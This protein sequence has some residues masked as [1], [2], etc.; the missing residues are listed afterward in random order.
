M[1]EYDL[2]F[3]ALMIREGIDYDDPYDTAHTGR[4]DGLFT[5]YG[6]TPA[7]QL[8]PGGDASKREEYV[9]VPGFGIDCAKQYYLWEHWQPLEKLL[10]GDVHTAVIEC[11]FDVSVHSGAGTAGRY[12]RQYG[13]QLPRFDD[14]PAALKWWDGFWYRRLKRYE[15][16]SRARIEKAGSSDELERRWVHYRGWAGRLLKLSKSL[17]LGSLS[18]S[19][20]IP[21]TDELDQT[22][23]LPDPVEVEKPPI[24]V[25]KATNTRRVEAMPY[26][27]QAQE[28]K[29]PDKPKESKWLRWLKIG[30]TA[31][32]AAGVSAAAPA[33]AVI[34]QVAPM[35]TAITDGASLKDVFIGGLGA[36]AMF[37][38]DKQKHG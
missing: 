32:A 37:F 3:D 16:I 11:L 26:V 18:E 19:R 5:R 24:V 12:A 8:A 29:T 17:F 21:Q 28:I 20:N 31:A 6:I 27:A 33:L 35:V 2:A 9:L 30:G 10:P 7:E 1:S 4:D 22:I 36:V 13:K 38:R 34:D 15:R 25:A 23:A 14:Y